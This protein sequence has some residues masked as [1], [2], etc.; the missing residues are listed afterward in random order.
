MKERAGEGIR[1]LDVQLGKM[2]ANEDSRAIAH[3]W[4]AERGRLVREI[5]IGS[6]GRS[7]SSECERGRG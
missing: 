7:V 5:A 2:S 1:T 4:P 3:F 6:D